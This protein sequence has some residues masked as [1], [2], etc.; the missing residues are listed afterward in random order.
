MRIWSSRASR[1]ASQERQTLGQMGQGQGHAPLGHRWTR[2]GERGRNER[3]EKG[4]G[5]RGGG[6]ERGRRRLEED[7]ASASSKGWGA[8]RRWRQEGPSPGLLSA[9]PGSTVGPRAQRLDWDMPG[10]KVQGPG[11]T[12]QAPTAGGQRW[13]SMACGIGSLFREGRAILCM[14]PGDQRALVNAG[15]PIIMT[16]SMF[17]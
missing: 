11:I 13:V 8:A 10:K 5:E 1:A 15:G 4:E 16:G 7:R 14:G 17:S 12:C 3:R 2:K 9:E 6:S